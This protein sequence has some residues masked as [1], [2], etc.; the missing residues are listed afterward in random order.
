MWRWP[1][2]VLR[3]SNSSIR[4]TLGLLV[5]LTVL[6]SGLA[7]VTTGA[8]TAVERELLR[9]GGLTQLDVSSLETGRA[10][11]ELDAENLDRVRDVAHV[12]EAVPDH[13][14]SIYTGSADPN[15]PTFDLTTHSWRPSTRPT[16]VRGEVPRPLRPGQLVL[17]V[18]GSGVDFNRFVGEEL[19]VAYTRA[20]GERSGTPAHTTF[21][22]VATYDPGW[23]FDGPDTAYVAPETAA[24][25]AAAKAGM[26][27]ERYRST[28]GATSA[29]VS[30][31]EQRNV[32]TVVEKLRELGFS[33]SPVADRVRNLPGVLGA[34]ELGYRIG[35]LVVLAVAVLTG[36]SSARSGLHHRFSELAVPR[37]PGDSVSGIRRIP[38][39][40][41]VLTGLL[42]GVVGGTAGFGG[43]LLLR[44]S[45]ERLLGLEV[46]VTDMLPSPLWGAALVL[47]P[48]IGLAV[49]ALLG[50]HV[51]LRR[52]PHTPARS[53]A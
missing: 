44:G 25:L 48:P 40:G 10:V 12:V 53:Q 13:V 15:A 51:A 24:V 41:T 43:A 22:V 46:G 6:V 16:I 52:D 23:R 9:S 18:H 31:S 20:T 32:P 26:S 1:G 35:I 19:P 47:A 8:R 34:A 30:V 39:G 5:V 3:R 4:S 14:S 11:R 7:S 33:A 21:E 36:S 27:P 50:G 2:A 29:V 49:G 28:T 17:P 45:L 38:L 37:I 42:A